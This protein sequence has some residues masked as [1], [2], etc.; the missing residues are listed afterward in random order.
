M[1]GKFKLGLKGS[2][3]HDDCPS[4]ALEGGLREWLDPQTKECSESHFLEREEDISLTRSHGSQK[5]VLCSLA[6]PGK[7]NPREGSSV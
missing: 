5:T 6:R 1:K 3:K 4:Q 7:G 2:N